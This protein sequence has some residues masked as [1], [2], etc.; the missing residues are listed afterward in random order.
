MST[1]IARASSTTI[2]VTPSDPRW[3]EFIASAKPTLFQS[4][5]WSAII[6]ESYGFC[7]KV[8]MV[9][10]EG[11]VAGG[12]PYAEVDDFR[13][14]R[15]V[16][17]PFADVCEPLGDDIWP[18]LEAEFFA[19]AL[20]WRVR[21]RSIPGSGRTPARRVAVHQHVPLLMT[22]DNAYARCHSKQRAKARQALRAGV[23]HRKLC[24]A[25]AIDL[26]YDLHTRVRKEKYRL[27]PQPRAFFEAIA[28]RFFPERGFVLVAE[29]QGR[30]IAA[31]WFL[32]YGDMLYYKFSASA[33][34]AL[35][36]RPNNYLI[37]KA[38][39]EGIDA[40]FAAIDLGISED[41]G[42]IGFKERLGAVSVPVYQASFCEPAKSDRVAKLES[43][44]ERVTAILTEPDV[45][46]RAA[47]EGGE[48]LYRFF[49]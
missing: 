6:E 29:L 34:D 5:D 44:L 14:R 41:E 16:S 23:T 17:F 46:L 26:F 4:P 38:I 15:R 32:A 37:W 21:T 47:Q 22:V 2:H 20:P 45:P 36:V 31:M 42:L 49:T 9:V 12:L 48:A 3:L 18:E 35:S 10:R 8:A 25:S 1:N 39:E 30:T 40:G 28:R 24:D 27:L 11:A 43:A 7:A 13:G 19:D 33:L